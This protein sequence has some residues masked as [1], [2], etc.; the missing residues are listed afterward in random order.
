[1]I[2]FKK[3]VPPVVL[4]SQL[5]GR[6]HPVYVILLGHIFDL[7]SWNIFVTA[8]S[9]GKWKPWNQTQEREYVVCWP[10]SIQMMYVMGLFN[11]SPIGLWSSQREPVESNISHFCSAWAYTSNHIWG[12]LFSGVAEKQKS[13]N[14]PDVTRTRSL[15]IWSQTRYQ[16]RHGVDMSYHSYILNKILQWL[17]RAFYRSNFGNGESSCLPI[18]Q[19][20]GTAT[21]FLCKD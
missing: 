5:P 19:A 3:F 1:M 6:Y 9:F 21:H 18:S 14:D 2:R 10:L 7:T 15:L 11:T 8:N 13:Y 12:C 16:L 17:G 4:N 20:F